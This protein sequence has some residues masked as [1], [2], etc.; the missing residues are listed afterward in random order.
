MDTAVF[1]EVVKVL[2]LG[3]ENVLGLLPVKVSLLQR[4]YS[5]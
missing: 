2:E 5:K 4:L 1:A 3:M